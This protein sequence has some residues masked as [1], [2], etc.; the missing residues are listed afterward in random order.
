MWLNTNYIKSKKKIVQYSTMAHEYTVKYKTQSR[1][2][3][4]DFL[5]M[6]PTGEKGIRRQV[7]K[8]LKLTW[9]KIRYKYLN[10]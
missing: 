6:L 4:A 1:R 2:I 5:I 7:E 9:Q 10:E 3:H 8:Y